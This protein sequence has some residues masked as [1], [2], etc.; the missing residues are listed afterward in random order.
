MTDFSLAHLTVLS[1]APPEMVSVAARCGYR[2][3]G[4][5]LVAVTPE[6]PGYPLMDD[7]A[8]LRETKRRLAD[9]DLS[10]L[11]VEFVR[12]ARGFDAKRFEPMLAAGAELGARYVISAPYDADV[13]ALTGH[14]AALADCARP[15]GITALMEFFAWTPV[16]S[17]A[18]ARSVVTATGCANVGVLVDTLH[19]DRTASPLEDLDAI[20]PAWL[21]MVH[22]CDAP[23]G[24]EP[25]LEAMLHTARAERL[26]PGDGGLDIRG[27]LRHMPANIP[28]A[29]EVPMETLTREA[30]PEAVARRAIEGARRL[31]GDASRGSGVRLRGS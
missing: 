12:L 14:L 5:R 1:L 16:A 9:N 10:V 2:H 8:G 4:L 23:A 25:S 20:P 29:L 3:V 31:L 7:P 21:P 22:V 27:V 11:D 19:M 24:R 15:Y 13:N 30:G 6:T 26:P 17:L 18:A 28:V